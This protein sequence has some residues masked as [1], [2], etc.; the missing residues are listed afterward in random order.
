MNFS[1]VK[2]EA[3]LFELDSFA[4]ESL[5]GTLT[6]FMVSLTASLLTA[7]GIPL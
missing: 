3:P 2:N 5:S 4:A 7:A 6:C 1:D